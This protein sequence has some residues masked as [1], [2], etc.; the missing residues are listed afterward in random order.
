MDI[1]LISAEVSSAE[2]V[3]TILPFGE[4]CALAVN[5]S[6]DC[7][8]TIL[9]TISLD[10]AKVWNG[11]FSWP[12]FG[13]ATHKKSRNDLHRNLSLKDEDHGQ[14]YNKHMKIFFFI[15]GFRSNFQQSSGFIGGLRRQL[16]H[17]W[18]W[19]Y[20]RT[21]SSSKTWGY[22]CG[23]YYRTPSWNRTSGCVDV[24]MERQIKLEN[25]WK[26]LWNL[27]LWTPGLQ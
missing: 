4:N 3:A 2:A 27:P 10:S 23:S 20:H 22:M 24:T 6:V 15:W 26:L 12:V 16:E 8:A 18:K 7:R 1:D 5:Q 25:V 17:V 19:I 11:G 14:S 13:V 9:F 21:P